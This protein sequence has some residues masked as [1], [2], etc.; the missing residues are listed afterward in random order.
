MFQVQNIVYI[1]VWCLF[2]VLPLVGAST[3]ELHSISFSCGKTNHLQIL[4]SFKLHEL[5][6]FR[7][8][9]DSISKTRQF[10]LAICNQYLLDGLLRWHENCYNFAN[11]VTLWRL[12]KNQNLFHRKQFEICMGR[13]YFKRKTHIWR[14]QT[15]TARY[16]HETEKERKN[17]KSKRT[18]Q[19]VQ[20]F[21]STKLIYFLA[22]SFRRILNIRTFAYVDKMV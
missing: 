10:F 21:S 22:F 15:S 2:F 16:K 1:A 20:H 17:S 13:H 7:I 8:R 6:N 18:N 9:F 4:K 11:G 19:S 14:N 5:L 3:I 12:L